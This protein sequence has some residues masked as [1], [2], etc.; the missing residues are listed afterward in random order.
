M[1]V[2]PHNLRAQFSDLARA[3]LTTGFNWLEIDTLVT[4]ILQRFLQRIEGFRAGRD[5]DRVNTGAPSHIL[6]A[7]GLVP[8]PGLTPDS[9][10]DYGVEHAVTAMD[11]RATTRGRARRNPVVLI[12]TWTNI[13]EIAV[14]TGYGV[15]DVHNVENN[16][17]IS[18]RLTSGAHERFNRAR[19]LRMVCGI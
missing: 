2:I 13:A 6:E 17:V 7:Y 15:Y 16:P 5:Q 12:G 3:Y 9:Y 8:M 11:M 1:P 19:F 10:Q 14:G 4:A 18:A